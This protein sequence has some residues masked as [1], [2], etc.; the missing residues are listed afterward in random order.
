MNW[1]S[2][3]Y[4][5]HISE[6]E[7]TWAQS[8][9]KP[10]NP[11]SPAQGSEGLMTQNEAG[12]PPDY[13]LGLSVS[14]LYE[15]F[16]F[17]CKKTECWDWWS[18]RASE[19]LILY[20]ETADDCSYWPRLYIDCRRPG[21]CLRLWT[22]QATAPPYRWWYLFQ[23]NINIINS[24]E[25]QTIFCFKI[26]TITHGCKIYVSSEIYN[27][28]QTIFTLKNSWKVKR[29]KMCSWCDYGYYGNDANTGWYG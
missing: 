14:F 17:F 5:G 11:R 15:F 25:K 9:S 22:S 29:I 21:Y 18:H 6:M 1:G 7:L 16:F 28:N 10:A 19:S 24:P 13:L 4:N 20:L 2:S 26:N 3:A 27:T 8:V 23:L 12:W